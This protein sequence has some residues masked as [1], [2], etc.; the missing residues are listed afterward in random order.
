MATQTAPNTIRDR[1]LKGIALQQAGE[2]EKAQRI[3][4]QAVKK[5][6]NNADAV[7]LLGVTY[8]QLG[9]PKRA[10][11]YIKKAITI[12]P[13]QSP[14]YA[15]LARTMLDLG[16]DSDSLLAVCNKALSLNPREREALNIKGI[17]LT[18]KKEFEEAE[19]IFQSLIVEDPDNKD[20]YRNFGTLLMDANRAN[21]AVNFFIKAVMLEPDNP[22][23]YLL[24]ARARLKLKQY[25]PSQYELTEALERFPENADVKHEAARLLF[26]MN[27]SNL[28]VFYSKQ[29]HEADPSDYHKCVTHG[30]NLLMHGDHKEA[31][32]VM[33]KAKKHAPPNNRT[34]DWNLALAYLANGDLKNGW[35]LHTAR[36]EDPSAQIL[37]RTF[38]V[39]EWQGEDISDKTILVWADQGLGDA[40][41]AGTMLPQLIKLAGK[42]IIELSEKGAK[43]T[44]YCFPEAVSRLARM[45]ENNFQTSFD[46]DLHVNIGELVKHFRPTLESFKTAP[47]PVYSFERDRAVEYL[48]RLKGYQDKPVIGFSWRSKNL[49][50]NRA[51][52][53]LSAPGVTPIL[54]SRDAIFVNLQYAALDKEL[55]YLKDQAGDHFHNFDDVDLF[56]DL[57]GAA[58]LTAACDFVVSANTSVADMAGILDVPAIRF[59]QQEPPLLLGQK[60]P[61][62]YPSMTYMHPY[63]DKACVEFVPEI[64]KEMDRQLENWTPERR[65][66]RLEL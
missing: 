3:Y 37:R 38:E 15:N 10:L 57:L 9:Y 49:A 60:N 48:K 24:R 32:Q 61:P 25:E 14:F 18:Q 5:A 47:C 16:T 54:K 21:H 23:N 22:E 13:N 12:D 4:K 45:D 31:L 17:A 50:V 11:E 1:L 52:Y 64:I 46:Y 2:F 58:A 19:M 8:R 28:A 51:R 36:F 6:P 7:H 34:V 44:Q 30:V 27:E 43:Y 63:T 35:E 66:K 62:W 55:N 39:P 41:K 29:A 59:G 65:N 42:V 33:K 56:D 53:Y 40:L 20:A 26:S